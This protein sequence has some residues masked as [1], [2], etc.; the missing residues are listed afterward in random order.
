LVGLC[1]VQ[2][3]SQTVALPLL[4][5]SV[6]YD[7]AGNLFFAD[8]NRNEVYESSLSGV[9]TVVAGN[10]V[11][12][13]GGDG[14][15][16]TAA[17]LNSPQGVAVGADG[18]LYIAD[19]GNERIRAVSGGV[20]STFAGNGSVGFAGDGGVALSAAFRLPNALAVDASGA[21]LVSD[22]GNARVRRISG[23][24]ISSVVGNG[25]QGFAGDGGAAVAAEID[26]PMGL[27]VGPDGR[28][29]VADS[30]NDRIRVVGTD[31]KIATF[32]GS[33]VRG[34]AGDGG[35]AT[36]ARLALP[37]GLI[38]TGGGAVIFAD[39]NNQRIRMVS[40]GG[41]ITTVVGSGVQGAVSDG[42]AAGVV[43]MNSPRGV[44]VSGFGSPVYADALSGLVRESIASAGV[45]VPAGLA[46]GRVSTVT[47]SALEAAGQVSATASVV[48]LVGTPQGVVEL[49]DGTGVVEQ[50]NLVE[51]VATFIPLTMSA[52]THSLSAEFMGD[53]V[54]PSATSAMVVVGSGAEVVTATANALSLEYGVAVPVL[55][56]LVSG[57]LAGDTGNVTVMFTTAAVE[58]SAPGTYAIVATLSGS[59][60]AKYSLVMG[61][62]SGSVVIGQATTLTVEQPLAQGS[63]A[64]L[65]LLLTAGVR[66]TT[67]GTPTGTVQFMDGATVV[68]TGAVING[69]AGG[70]YLS[71]GAGTHSIVASY[72]GDGDFIAS[73]SMAVVTSV[74]AMP[75]FTVASAGSTTQTVVGGGVANFALI[76]GGQSGAFTGVVDLSANGLP[77]L[78]TVSFSPP[79]VVPGSGQVSVMMSVQTNAS[80]ARGRTEMRYGILACLLLPWLLMVKR[81]RSLSQLLA[82]GCAITLLG[83]AV[84]CG[85]RSIS[86]T[87]P[88]EQTYVLT[89]TGTSTNLAGVVVHH[90][91]NV[92]LVVQ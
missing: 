53:G 47:L 61:A 60:S 26:T 17:E 88:G 57:V 28:V 31:G 65:P 20:I 69:I 55:T 68:A 8:T 39:S 44:A 6:A 41:T 67:A 76:V 2:G 91:I 22:A 62:G 7:A 64:G 71:P 79:Q 86:T 4:P 82:M 9:L 49:L 37:R 32:A 10:G 29:F 66:S 25:V 54:N 73:T 77:A 59:A 42:V 35:A 3:R 23:G 21:L 5:T 24:V 74:G 36:G 43:G 58:F 30:H 85:A 70:T 18:T 80:V 87:L 51:G 12:G 48:G 78:A 50:T 27:A 63:Y 56:G 90:T 45:V 46:P 84:G 75:D 15:A 81:R 72:G 13:F 34:F 19:T 40:A 14:G 92:T 52:G 11:Q 89:V 16:A 33:G 83:G 1:G 38:V